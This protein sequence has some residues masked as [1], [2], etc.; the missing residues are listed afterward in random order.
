MRA[1]AL[2][3]WCWTQLADTLQEANGLVTENRTPKLPLARLRSLVTGE[4]TP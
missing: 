1:G 2:A 3:G 4:P